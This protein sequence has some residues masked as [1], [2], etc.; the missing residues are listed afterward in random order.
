MP[1][2]TEEKA[3]RKRDRMIANVREK[4]QSPAQYARNVVATVFQAMIRAEVAARPTGLSPA[5]IDGGIAS[6]VRVVGQC[7]CITCGKVRP[8]KS[9]GAAAGNNLLNGARDI[10]D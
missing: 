2:S 9:H 4:R 6:V 7:V 8:W 5:A 1:L 10:I 3:R